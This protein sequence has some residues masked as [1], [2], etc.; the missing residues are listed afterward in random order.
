MVGT[1]TGADCRN[2]GHGPVRRG[3]AAG[4]AAVGVA[5]V[6][7]GVIVLST[8]RMSPR[9]RQHFPTA[10]QGGRFYV[11]NGLTVVGLSS[12]G[13]LSYYDHVWASFVVLAAAMTLG[14]LAFFRYRPR[15]S[16]AD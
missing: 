7:Y 9:D 12:A 6:I 14:G 8:G 5:P 4:L 13:L 11:C 2:P 16:A 3:G 15:R 1:T 10:A